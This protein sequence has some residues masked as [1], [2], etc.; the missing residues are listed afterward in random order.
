[1]AMT[2]SIGIPHRLVLG[3]RGLADGIVEYRNRRTG[4]EAKISLDDIVPALQ[5]RLEAM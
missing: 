3:E 4:E 2:R 1:M 5:E